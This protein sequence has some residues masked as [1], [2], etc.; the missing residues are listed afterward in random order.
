MFIA[1]SSHTGRRFGSFDSC[2]RPDRNASLVR[3]G[4]GDGRSPQRRNPWRGQN[5]K[6][7]LILA[8]AGGLA[9]AVASASAAFAQDCFI[10]NRS[11][12]GS[13]QA[14]THSNAWE[15]AVDIRVIL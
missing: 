6:K 10:A 11:D 9:L 4:G 8:A 15:V 12:R 7:R 14:A 1:A 5:V 13:L 2:A 3:L